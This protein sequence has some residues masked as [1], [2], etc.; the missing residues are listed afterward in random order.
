MP[1]ADLPRVQRRR[2]RAR[3]L[4]RGDVDR[5]GVRARR[6]RA[7][8][9]RGCPTRLRVFLLTLVVVDDLVALLVI[10]VAYTEHLSFVALAIALALF[11]VLAGAALAPR[12]G[13]AP[14]YVVLGVGDLARDASSRASTRS[15][16]G[17][18]IGLATTA[19]P[20]ARA[21][22]ERGDRAA[23]ARSASSRRRSSP[24]RPGSGWRP[25]SRPTSACRRCCHPWTSYVIVPLFALA[26][27]GITSTASLLR[28]ARH[29]RRSRS[30]SSSATSSASRSGSSARPGS[31]TRSA[32]RLRP[33][34][35]WPRS[36]AAARSPASGSRSRC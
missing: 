23:P 12:R 11:G 21:D 36:P 5:H 34:V 25:R 13:A 7:R 9:R 19:Y 35:G 20:P 26:N 17:L 24:A 29:A 10:A 2:R 27:A 15:I 8:R 16:A 31:P 22:L 30:A 33:P 14:A 1:V 6:A 4:G 18:A 28:D 3:R 32:G